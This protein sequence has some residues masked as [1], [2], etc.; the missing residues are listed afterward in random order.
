MAD[1]PRA[2]SLERGSLKVRFFNADG[3]NGE[4]RVSFSDICAI[5][6]LASF[7]LKFCHRTVKVIIFL[8]T[9]HLFACQNDKC[10]ANPSLSG[11]DPNER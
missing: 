5:R 6:P 10:R 9:Q 1:T 4:D 2:A 8:L 3:Q 11:H 7:A